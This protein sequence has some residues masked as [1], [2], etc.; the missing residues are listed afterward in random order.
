MQDMKNKCAPARAGAGV[1]LLVPRGAV[2]GEAVAAVHRATL[3]RAEG[4]LGRLSTVAARHVEHL[5]RA[6]G[7]AAEAAPATPTILCHF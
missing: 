6:R 7:T 2:L 1:A 5:T 4:H 3:R